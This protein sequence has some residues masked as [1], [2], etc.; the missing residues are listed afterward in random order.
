MNLFPEEMRRDP[1]PLYD[2]MRGSSPV[3]HVAP[4]DLWMIFDH[5]GVKRALTD[6]EAFSSVVTPV[7][8]K[9][10]DWLI[11]SDPPRHTKLRAIVMRAFTARSVAALEPRV[12]EVSRELLDQQI[13][14]GEMDLALDYADLLPT[15]VI[16]EM[17]GIPPADRAR[18]LCWSEAIVNLSYAIS[19][20][21][22]AERMMSEHAAAK[23]EMEAYL[24]EV[25]K[26]RRRA[27]KD[28]LLTRL[29]EAEVDGERL[30]DDEILGFFQVLL[31]AG[32]ETTT[33]LIGN[34]ILCLVEHPQE[35]ARL[36]ASPDLLPSAIEEVLRYRS[37]VQIA[38]RE[39]RRDVE[40]HGQVIP[41]G[42]LV[43]PV[44]GSANRDPQQ[45]RDPDRFDIGRDP[46][47]HV[48]FGQGVHFCLGA[49]LARLEARIA[50]SDLL[51]R[52]RGLE[53]ASEEPWEPR[54]PLNV[55]GPA[56]LPIRFEPGA[57]SAAAG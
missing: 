25:L 56:R 1:Y 48:A 51:S 19:G 5:E 38:F 28:D 33:N 49:P 16:A 47:P 26:A 44:I 46:N 54:K 2:Q 8:G 55:L 6:H 21:D 32:T 15:T 34:A 29:V 14:R 39:A 27:P 42:K 18:F 52:L 50:L 37:P 9:A 30:T 36:R 7:T 31:A 35:L 22:E 24:A 4:L 23:D 10:P 57:R 45:F 12:R 13:E 20:G 43:V 17:L 3:L 40:V 11:F 41:A 53:L